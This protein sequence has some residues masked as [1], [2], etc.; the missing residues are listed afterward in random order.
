MAKQQLQWE[1]AKYQGEYEEILKIENPTVRK[2]LLKKFADECDKAAVHLKAAALPRQSVNVLIPIP[3]MKDNEVYAPK[4]RD[5]EKIILIRYPHGGKFEIPELVVNNNNPEAR[6]V[7]GTDPTVDAIGLNKR[8]ADILSGADFDGDTAVCIPNNNNYIQTKNPLKELEN[9]DPKERYP[10]REG[11]KVMTKSGTQAEMG[12]ITNLIT[13][14]QIRGD[15]TDE[16]IARAVK[17]SMVVIDAAKHKLDYK[18]SEIDNDIASLKEKY[19]GGRNHGASTLISK[20][21]SKKPVPERDESKERIDKDT[22][23]KIIFET[24]RARS[25]YRWEDGQKI[26]YGPDEKV[27]PKAKYDT[28]YPNQPGYNTNPKALVKQDS[29]K[30]AEAKDAYELSSGTKM[31]AVYADYANAMKAFANKARLDSEA[32]KNLPYNPQAAIIFKDEVKSIED[33]IKGAVLR[34]PIN[35]QVERVSNYIVQQKVKDNPQLYDKSPEGKKALKKLRNQVEARQRAKYGQKEK[36]DITEKE[37]QAV[38]SGAL[39][40][41][42]LTNLLQYADNDRIREL[43][44]PKDSKF[45]PMSSSEISLARAMLNSGHTLAEVADALNVSAS[46]ISKYAR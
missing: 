20:A 30:M 27:P 34:A 45:A 37:W 26:Y 38:Q 40:I 18:L 42:T 36:F 17:H 39:R 21:S 43:A 5:G 32:Q 2:N 22:G 7:I 35:R 11:M 25:Y 15:A 41:T 6:K 4:Y 23:E 13:D 33:K 10:Y 1:Y 44:M 29:K 31:E 16:E 12:K 3:S 14:M 9:F 8:V 19:Q 46:T 24:K 28:L